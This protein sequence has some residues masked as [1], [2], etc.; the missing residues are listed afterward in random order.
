MYGGGTMINKTDEDCTVSDWV[1]VLATIMVFNFY[2]W[3]YLGGLAYS[4]AKSLVTEITEEIDQHV[5]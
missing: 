4:G 3:G 5:Q 2:A 1:I